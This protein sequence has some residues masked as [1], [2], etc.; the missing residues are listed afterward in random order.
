MSTAFLSARDRTSRRPNSSQDRRIVSYR[1]RS[2]EKTRRRI[3]ALEQEE[4]HCLPLRVGKFMIS[5]EYF[6]YPLEES[7]SGR[8]KRGE[9]GPTSNVSLWDYVRWRSRP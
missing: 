5:P 6:K 4:P 2:D 9:N 1:E 8:I 7:P 3:S